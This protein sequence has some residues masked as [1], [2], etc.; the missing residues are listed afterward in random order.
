MPYCLYNDLIIEQIKLKKKEIKDQE[1]KMK[2]HRQQ[3]N[4]RKR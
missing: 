4:N 3:M 2:I 1:E